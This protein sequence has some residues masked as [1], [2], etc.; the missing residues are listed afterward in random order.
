MNGEF[1]H[2]DLPIFSPFFSGDIL[3]N[4]PG[5]IYPRLVEV[6]VSTKVNYLIEERPVNKMRL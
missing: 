4:L 2:V 1:P 3:L 5:G 6:C